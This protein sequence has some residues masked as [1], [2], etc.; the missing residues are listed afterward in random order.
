MLSHVP[1]PTGGEP[2][3]QTGSTASSGGGA[4]GEASPRR[5]LCSASGDL[6]PPSMGWGQ[7]GLPVSLPLQGHCEGSVR[8]RLERGT[9]ARPPGAASLLIGAR[10]RRQEQERGPPGPHLSPV[11]GRGAKG[12]GRG[13]RCWGS[14]RT[15]PCPGGARAPVSSRGGGEMGAGAIYVSRVVCRQ[16]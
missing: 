12:S 5:G 3:V 2:R 6:S 9:R 11:L 1:L 14:R 16:G 13:A 4:V 10:R 7:H 15:P 8:S